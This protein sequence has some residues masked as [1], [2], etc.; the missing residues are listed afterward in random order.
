MTVEDPVENTIR[1]INQVQVNTKA[2]MTFA[3]ALR[4]FLRQDPD[5]IMVGEIRDGETAEIATRS[6]I[7]GHLVFSTLHTNDAPSS[8]TRMIDMGIE[9]FLISSSVV[10]VLAQRLVRRL[11]PKCKEKAEIDDYARDILGISKDEEVT[12]YKAKGCPECN[13][14]GYKGRIAVY[15]IMEIDRDIR[16]LIAKNANSDA[17]KDAAISKGMKTLRMNCAR[18]VKNG[19]TTID[20][21]LKI[22]FSKD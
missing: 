5:I 19:T 18:L 16:Q 12:I 11:C 21:M 13:D 17:I 7:T 14:I 8:I 15:E 9:P 10:G 6:A 20:E 22:A 4:S 1:G 3:A 2:G